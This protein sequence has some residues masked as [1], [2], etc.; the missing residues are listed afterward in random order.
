M[1]TMPEFVSTFLRTLAIIFE[2][3]GPWTVALPQMTTEFWDLLL[4]VRSRA[5]A[6]REYDVLE[7]LLFGLLILLEVNGEM[8]EQ[9]AKAHAKELVETQEWTK[10]ILDRIDGSDAQGAKIHT[11]AAAVIFRCGEVVEKWQRLM[12][13]DMIGV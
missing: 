6:N 5:L 13:G 7:A 10:L 12:V 4:S 2:A 3:S 9:L 11:L 8:K 1:L